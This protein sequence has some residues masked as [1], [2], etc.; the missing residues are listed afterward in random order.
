MFSAPHPYCIEEKPGTEATSKS[1]SVMMSPTLILATSKSTSVM[2]SPT[3]ATSKS[4]SVMISP[5]GIIYLKNLHIKLNVDQSNKIAT[6]NIV[7]IAGAIGT[8]MLLLIIIFIIVHVCI[9]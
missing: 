6:S 4:T 2:M 7:A 8:V 1:T 5:T 9:R 3:L